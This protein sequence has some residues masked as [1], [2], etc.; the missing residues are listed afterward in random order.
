MLLTASIFHPMTV[1]SVEH[2]IGTLCSDLGPAL[3]QLTVVLLAMACCITLAETIKR[4][5]CEQQSAAV[6]FTPVQQA[7]PNPA[8][9]RR[10]QGRA[11]ARLED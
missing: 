11:G 5:A 3:A 4:C 1:R 10:E 7:L 9:A 8:A 6:L 2:F